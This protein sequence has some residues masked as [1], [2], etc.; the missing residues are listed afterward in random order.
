MV[1]YLKKKATLEVTELHINT[2]LYEDNETFMLLTA[3][4]LIEKR[5]KCKAPFFFP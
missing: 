4:C 3:F 2:D 5:L 1:P